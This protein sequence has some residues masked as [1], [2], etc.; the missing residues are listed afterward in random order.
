GFQLSLFGYEPQEDYEHLVKEARGRRLF[1]AV[2]D[3][4]L[5]LLKATAQLPHGGGMRIGLDSDEYRAIRDW[6]EQGMHFSHTSDAELISIDVEPRKST[7]SFHGQEQLQVIGEFS[8]GTVRDVTR[9]AM[10][11]P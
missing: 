11:E 9:L 2:P 5:L 1:P 10:F 3:H 7:V 4:S 6:I 8:D